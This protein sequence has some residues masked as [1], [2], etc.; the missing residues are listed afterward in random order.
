ME[1]RAAAWG[2]MRQGGASGWRAEP[3]I[4]AFVGASNMTTVRA[5]P[6]ERQISDENGPERAFSAAGERENGLEGLKIVPQGR[7]PAKIGE[8]RVA[9]DAG[10]SKTA[11]KRQKT[12]KFTANAKWG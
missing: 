8:K 6:R 4:C 7:E 2:N 9:T 11:R 1:Q 12:T 3:M 10:R 5:G